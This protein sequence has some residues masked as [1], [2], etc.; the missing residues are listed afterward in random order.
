[1]YRE[2]ERGVRCV[3]VERW[4]KEGCEGCVCV[5][6]WEKEGCEGCVCVGRW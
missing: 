4:E 2:V 3:C 6:R 1:M 5:G